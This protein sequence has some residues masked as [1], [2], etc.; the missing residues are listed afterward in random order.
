MDMN[1]WIRVENR[2]PDI[3]EDVWV[4]GETGVTIG[5]YWRN[6]PSGNMYWTD[7]ADQSIYG[8]THWMKMDVPDPPR[9]VGIGS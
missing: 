8:V 3:H 1:K 7:T 4:Y 5:S 6:N 2:L 9:Q